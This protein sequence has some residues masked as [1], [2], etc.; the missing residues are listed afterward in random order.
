LEDLLIQAA[1]APRL[2]GT[3]Q[4]DQMGLRLTQVVDELNAE[5][6]RCLYL[7]SIVKIAERSK[8][9]GRI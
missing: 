9:R 2:A 6:D 1:R 5:I 3:I 4:D 8:W 7:K